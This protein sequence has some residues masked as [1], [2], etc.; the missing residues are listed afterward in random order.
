LIEEFFI[1]K[2]LGMVN[3]T[4]KSN[5][6]KIDLTKDDGKITFLDDIED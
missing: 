5:I 4:K 3:T 6:V 2:H 1:E